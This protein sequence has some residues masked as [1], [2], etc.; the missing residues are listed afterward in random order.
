MS[1]R[2]LRDTSEFESQDLWIGLFWMLLNHDQ[3]LPSVEEIKPYPT[4]GSF[5]VGE[6]ELLYASVTL[7]MVQGE[8]N[9]VN[10]KCQRIILKC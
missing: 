10:F 4:K 9:L 7:F 8:E 3:S 1:C 6:R 2:S 5:G